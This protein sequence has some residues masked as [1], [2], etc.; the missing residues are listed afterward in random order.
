MCAFGLIKK[1]QI[2]ILCLL[3]FAYMN[4]CI[5]AHPHFTFGHT[6]AQS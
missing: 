5:P 2:S 3:H 1:L 4:I 6:W